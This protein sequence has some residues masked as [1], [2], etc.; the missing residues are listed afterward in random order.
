[1]VGFAVEFP[2]PLRHLLRCHA[3]LV[4]HP[5]EGFLVQVQLL[6]LA[7]LCFYRIQLG[8]ERA[9]GVFQLIKQFR[10]DGEQI[11][12]GQPHD[13]IDVP[14]TRSHELR[15]VSVFPI[16]VV[17]SRDGGKSRILVGRDLRATV[18]FPMP[19]INT[20]DERRDQRHTGFG[21]RHSLRK[22][23]QEC[24]IAVNPVFIAKARK[25]ISLYEK[26]SVSRERVPIKIAST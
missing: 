13:L 3:V 16:V 24:Q 9:L 15:F 7:R 17:D 22:A 1:M 18:R 14:K 19:V 20:T 26:R 6:V 5:A 11:A 23:E 2:D 4:V 21:A 10:A 8:I 25:L 12:S